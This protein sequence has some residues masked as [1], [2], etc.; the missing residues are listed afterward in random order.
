MKIPFES[1]GPVREAS[2]E[3]PPSGEFLVDYALV[4]DPKR[5]RTVY[6]AAPGFHRFGNAWTFDGESFTQV[7]DGELHT[8]DPAQRWQGVFD[9]ARGA[10]VAWNFGQDD[11]GPVTYGVVLRDGGPELLS[12]SGEHPVR[13]EDADDVTGGLFAYDTKRDVTVCMTAL[14]VWELDAKGVWKRVRDEDGLPEASWPETSFGGV[15]DAKSERT[16]FYFVCED[17][18]G[19]DRF[20]LW[21]WDGKEL[22]L[23]PNDGLPEE[24]ITAGVQTGPVLVAHPDGVI[25]ELGW[26]RHP[27]VF[28]GGWKEWKKVHTERPATRKAQM[29]YDAR[30]AAFV[31]G[32]G[33]YEPEPEEYPED[34]HVFYVGSYAGIRGKWSKVGVT[35]K[36][37]A[38]SELWATRFGGFAGG[39]WRVMGDYHLTLLEWTDEGWRTIVDESGQKDLWNGGGTDEGTHALAGLVESDDGV[40]YT[41]ANDGQVFALEGE[42]WVKKGAADP[43]WKLRMWTNLA[44]DRAG[45]RI[46]AWGGELRGRKTNQLLF[47]DPGTAQ[48]TKAKK[49]SPQPKGYA[50]SKDESTVAHQLVWDHGLG[51]VV[52]IGWDEAAVLNGEVFEPAFPARMGELNDDSWRAV[53]SDPATG[54]TLIVSFGTGVIF[55]FDLGGCAE[56][57]RF[58]LPDDLRIGHTNEDEAWRVLARDWAFDAA[59][60]ELHVQNPDDAW[61]HYVLALGPAF[62]AAK[63]LGPRTR[64]DGAVPRSTVA[65]YRVDGDGAIAWIGESEGTKVTVE[66]GAIGEAPAVAQETASSP[67]AAAQALD[68]LVKDARAEGFVAAAEL[69]RDALIGLACV[70]ARAIR[71]RGKVDRGSPGS[72]IGG[73][74]ADADLDAWPTTER[75]AFQQIQWHLPE[76]MNF[77]EIPE[78]K[79][80]ELL[81][82]VREGGVA[83]THPLGF[84]LQ[85]ET[86]DLLREHAGV[87]VFVDTSGVATEHSLHNRVRL[88]RREAWGKPPACDPQARVL[89]ARALELGEPTFEIDE[90]RVAT[91]L[92]RDPELAAALESLELPEADG[93]SK[94]GGVP[95]WVQSEQ[96]LLGK[97]G[98]PY[99]FICSVDFDSLSSATKSWPDAGLAGVL[100]VFANAEETAACAFWQYT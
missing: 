41:V 27:L 44:W 72:R 30:L 64:P 92:S 45:K 84:L 38:I 69:S 46:V 63:K 52:R 93:W 12:L 67:D 47:W 26:R 37:S 59:T 33:E 60:R 29:T 9:A 77:F 73:V 83:K 90:A 89:P 56:I 57:G 97:G 23:L 78:E 58:E 99:R 51:A 55:R 76:E 48:W 100:Y 20:W 94:V 91:L 49:S 43:E 2:I 50:R 32:P 80:E 17:E 81:A 88:V 13:H 11:D 5:E 71:L 74:P 42:R 18:E 6:F 96:V 4:Y 68:V 28:D 61:G 21:A 24:L 1:R 19:E 8:E 70:P 65:L 66:R 15:W 53:A 36:K 79:R 82:D 62:D 14:G 39:R 87:A 22:E 10:V 7:S 16:F 3:L 25:A 54:Q 95:A 98:V 85:I 34:Q 35:E 86:G 31:C 75:E 40:V